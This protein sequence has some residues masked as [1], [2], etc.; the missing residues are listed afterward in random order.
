MIFPLHLKNCLIDLFADDTT[1]STSGKNVD[2]VSKVLS[3]GVSSIEHWCTENA[4]TINTSKTKL[5]KISSRKK[6]SQCSNSLNLQIN[7]KI[8]ENVQHTKLLGITIDQNLTWEKHIQLLCSRISSKLS[9]LQRLKRYLPYHIR[10]L[11][12]NAYVLPILDYCCSVW[13]SATKGS[14]ECILKLQKRAARIILNA[15]Y[16]TPSHEMFK[17]LKWMT[18]YDRI[19]FHKAI[20]VYK[21]LNSLSPNY[22]SHRLVTTGSVYKKALRSTTS[23]NLI[24]PKPN[25]EFYKRSFIYSGTVLWNSLPTS[26][27]QSPSLPC[28]RSRLQR[29]ILNKH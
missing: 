7:G 5:M 24:V 12:Y 21:C 18:I 27:K 13:G 2:D 14:L 10:I 11:F 23:L 19:F 9:L 3:N 29:F 15:D 4:M 6:T 26:M 16:L 20:L 8:I 1:I 22:L 17:T 25:T 28:F